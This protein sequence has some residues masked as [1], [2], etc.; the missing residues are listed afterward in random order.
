MKQKYLEAYM[1]MAERFAQTSEANRLKVAAMIIKNDS[2]L[3]LGINGSY[4]GWETNVCETPEGDTAWY[5]RHAEGAALDKMLQS[6]ETTT[7]AS[8]VV[9]HAPC[10]MCSL[11]IKAAGITKVYYRHAYRDDSG[12]L[13]LQNNGVDV[14]QL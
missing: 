9:T 8:M 2:V 7:D 13:Y 4:P 5:V 10:K 12:I 11:K 6:H 1:D 14:Q 3:A